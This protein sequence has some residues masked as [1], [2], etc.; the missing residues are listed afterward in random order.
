MR[1]PCVYILASRPNGSLYIGVTSNLPKRV[2]EHKNDFVKGFT[3]RYHVHT[4]VWYE[5][6]ESMESAIVREKS[7]KKWNRAWKLRLIQRDNP[8]WLDL[9]DEIC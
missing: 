1:T 9:Y 4:L 6:H 7:L 3:N 2:W 8:K 5:V